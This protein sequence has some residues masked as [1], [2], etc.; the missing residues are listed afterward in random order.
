MSL[1][2]TQ[3]DRG[4]G[5]AGG[6]RLRICEKHRGAGA[7]TARVIHRDQQVVVTHRPASPSGLAIPGY[8]FVETRR[9]VPRLSSLTEN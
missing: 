3:V 5:L 1:W 6:E 9:H 8:L 7:L 4:R 2:S